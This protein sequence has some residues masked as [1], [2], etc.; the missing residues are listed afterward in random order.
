MFADWDREFAAMCAAFVSTPGPSHRMMRYDSSAFDFD[1]M[2]HTWWPTTSS[3]IPP[4]MTLEY[5]N[6]GP[7]VY[8]IGR[9]SADVTYRLHFDERRKNAYEAEPLITNMSTHNL[10]TLSKVPV[11]STS[12]TSHGASPQLS[13]LDF[14]LTTGER[15]YVRTYVLVSAAVATINP[16][17]QL[18]LMGHAMF[19]PDVV[20]METFSKTTTMNAGVA[21]RQLRLYVRSPTALKP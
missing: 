5:Q 7:Y 9:V 4:M 16:R 20:D 14:H 12:W 10:E 1:Y 19:V 2:R 3:H 6:K 21:M 13:T 18:E 15:V 11:V 8:D 17:V